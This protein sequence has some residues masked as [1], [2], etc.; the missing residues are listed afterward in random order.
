MN[1]D[2]LS[3]YM[4]LAEQQIAAAF[5]EENLSIDLGPAWQGPYTLTYSLHLYQPNRAN[6][7]RALDM[8]GPIE[9]KV[10]RGPA[11]VYR[12]AGTLYVEIPS[13]QPMTVDG[14]AHRG[15][16]LDV[17]LGL[18]TRGEVVGLDWARATH[19]LLI[20]PSQRGKSTA[21]RNIAFHL[22]RQ[23]SPHDVAFL[24]I[25]YKPKDW[26]AFGSLAHTW[27]A[28]YD[29]D[30]I[31]AALRWIIQFIPRRLRQQASRPA[32]FLF[33]DDLANLVGRNPAIADL[34][35][36]IASLGAGAGVHL[37]VGTQRLSGKSNDPLLGANVH[38]R[39]IFGTA[40]AADAA[41]YAGR[42]GTG[43]HLIG[44]YPGDT[45]LITD[46][47]VQRVAVGYIGDEHLAA[48][49]QSARTFRPWTVQRTAP[50]P[51]PLPAVAKA[52]ETPAE[53]IAR[54]RAA[55]QLPPGLLHRQPTPADADAL[56]ELY[57]L[58]EG[59]KEDLY[60]AAHVVKNSTRSHWI[61]LA[62]QEGA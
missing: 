52:A 8:T 35:G 28:V 39:L 62:L 21:M 57:R 23:N 61:D 42:S 30:E 50:A 34:L 15:A 43:G 56:R 4:Q 2:Q 31:M 33:V 55:V 7:R 27:A 40:S 36:E 54:A 14:T 29:P 46:A 5:V 24:L 1:Q 13:P 53:R 9:A 18:S 45:L 10:Q 59:R 37:V 25:S 48:L 44:A 12:N 16:G 60:P 51:A 58:L 22:A 6:I 38:L 11:R 32:V 17:P 49:P 41:L 20:G 19:M 3:G 47:G 26:A